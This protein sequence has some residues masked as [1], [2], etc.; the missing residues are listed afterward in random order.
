MSDIEKIKER[1][2]YKARGRLY[3]EF[4]VGEKVTHHWGRTITEADAVQFSYLTLS[5]NPLYFNRE[6]A[7]AH[8]HP[9]IVVN[10][11]LVFNIILGLTVEDCSEGIGGPFLGVYELNY[12]QPVYPGDTLTASSTTIDKRLSESDSNRGIVSWRSEGFNQDGDRVLEFKRS[13][14]AVFNIAQMMRE[15][16]I[17]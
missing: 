3:E 4:E 10:P 17:G 13:N 5:Y 7:K 16:K 11:Q 14:L 8:G 1:A 2:V 6:Y 9:D 15:G 12:L